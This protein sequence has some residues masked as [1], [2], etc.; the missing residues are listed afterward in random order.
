LQDQAT[1]KE[2]VG[3]YTGIKEGLRKNEKMDEVK[4]VDEETV[5]QNG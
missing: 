2:E 4:K 1:E 3:N 5:R